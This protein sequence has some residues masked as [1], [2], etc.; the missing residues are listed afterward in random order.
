MIPILETELRSDGLES[1]QLATQTLGEMYAD[2]GG[3]DLV[4]KYPTTWTAWINRKSDIAVAVRLKCIEATPGL[5]TNLPEC[6]EILAG[7]RFNKLLEA[8]TCS[9]LRR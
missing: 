2:K 7:M 5:I 9:I 4:R 3:M 8:I 1:R 6:R